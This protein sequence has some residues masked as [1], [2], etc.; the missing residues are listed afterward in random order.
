MK[1][2][3]LGI[4][5]IVSTYN[6]KEALHL[7]L[8]SVFTQERLPDEII[9]AD[10]G[11][12]EDTRACIDGLRAQSPVP[13]VHVWH[14]DTGFRLAAI[15]NKAIREAHHEYIV[16][17]DGDLILSPTFVQDHA[18]LA[19]KGHF[20]SGSRVLLSEDTS[21]RLLRNRSL[22]VRKHSAGNDRNPLNRMRSKLL[23]H[24]SADV[25][26][27][28]GRNKYHVKGCN[29]SFWRE[30]LLR[31]NG[32]NERFT[33]WGHED[34]EIAIRLINAGI[35]KRFLKMGGVC[36]HLYHLEARRALEPRNVEM[37]NEA[38]SKGTIRAESGLAD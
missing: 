12:R 24:L 13:I 27:Q 28:Y 6:W 7:C 31:V 9:V 33:G 19:K 16:Q 38:I 25:Y 1:T 18:E 35:K 32:Y 10:D 29:M 5:L 30:D 37:M 2:T 26:K 14:E 21:L 23:R 20:I 4:S 8:R 22:D 3:S 17:I 34:R 15:R 11:S 36:Y